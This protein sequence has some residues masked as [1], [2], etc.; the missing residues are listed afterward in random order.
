MSLGIALYPDH[1]AD[2]ESLI[3]TSAG[4]PLEARSRGGS[5]VLFPEDL[6]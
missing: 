6:A 2:A 1:G 4:L 3:K 5:L